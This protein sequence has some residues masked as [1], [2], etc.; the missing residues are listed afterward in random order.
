MTMS[1][2]WKFAVEIRGNPHAAH[3]VGPST[4]ATHKANDVFR[5][6][7]FACLRHPS[8]NVV[9]LSDPDTMYVLSRQTPA[10]HP[11]NESRL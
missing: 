5:K 9:R 6:C 8:D 11:L 4:A 3:P 2:W 1:W 10:M 7:T